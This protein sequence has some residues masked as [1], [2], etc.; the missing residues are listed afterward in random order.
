M[1]LENL[2]SQSAEATDRRE[3][4][5]LLEHSILEALHPGFLVIFLRTDDENL[6]VVSGTVPHELEKVSVKIPFLTELSKNRRLIELPLAFQVA[7]TANSPFAVL[8]PECAVPMIGR[9]GRLTGLLLLGT[10]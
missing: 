4:A 3:L 9:D 5:Q 8:C 6:E 10:R 2:A 1:I 7:G